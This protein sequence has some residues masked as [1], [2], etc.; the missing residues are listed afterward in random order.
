MLAWNQ[1]LLILIKFVANFRKTA[2]SNNQNNEITDTL[3]SFITNSTNWGD[4]YSQTFCSITG[5][6]V[7][8]ETNDYSEVIVKLLGT[9]K[10]ALTTNK[11]FFRFDFLF[12]G[13]YDIKFEK[14]QL[15]DLKI[16]DIE[17][18]QGVE[19]FID[20]IMKPIHNVITIEKN[21]ISWATRPVQDFIYCNNKFWFLIGGKGL[22]SYQPEAQTEKVELWEDLGIDGPYGLA[23]VGSLTNCYDN[24][25]WVCGDGMSIINRRV[26]S[27]PV[28]VIDSI[29]AYLTPYGL[30]WDEN[31]KSLI[32]ISWNS[33]I[34]TLYNTI[35]H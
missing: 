19:I 15:R 17:I 22:F 16:I 30:G 5:N 12:P 10:T 6:I 32:G 31:T 4:I 3:G 34:I 7:V 21:A 18:T 11:G 13:K 24:T 35:E 33:N 27:S 14:E 9:D 25:F 23:G 8:P 20:T 26:N 2:V 29:Q 28:S 1:G